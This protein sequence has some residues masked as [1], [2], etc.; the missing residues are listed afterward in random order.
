M[1][2]ELSLSDLFYIENFIGNLVEKQKESCAMAQILPIIGALKYSIVN[3]EETV[4][5][6]QPRVYDYEA[7]CKYAYIYVPIIN[8]IFISNRKQSYIFDD[9]SISANHLILPF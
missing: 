6:D 4:S 9:Q 5:L 8:S 1:G 2:L 3:E 7:L